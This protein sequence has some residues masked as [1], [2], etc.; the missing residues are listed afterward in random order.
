MRCVVAGGAGFVGSHLC[1]ALVARGHKV[2]CIDN[3]LTGRL[4]NLDSLQ[5][6]ASFQFLRQDV[7]FPFAVSGPVDAVLHL[8]SPAS[9]PDYLRFPLETLRVGAQGTERLLELAA[10]RGARYLLASTSEVYGD[11]AIH[12]QTEEY[13]GYVNPNGPRSVYDE[14]KRFAEALS[15]AYRRARGVDVRVAR[16]FNTYGPRMR[17]DDGRVVSNFIVQA[18]SGRPLTIY[19]DGGQTRSLCFVADLVDGL[20]RLLFLDTAPDGPINIGNPE[21]I[22]I[23][24]LARLVSKI[25]AT[26]CSTE[27]RPLPRDDPKRRCPDIALARRLLGWNPQVD[28]R[29]GLAATVRYFREALAAAPTDHSASVSAHA[30]GGE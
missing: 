7:S 28:A 3:V 15:F 4:R 25:C 29:T 21:E 19:G 22:T 20:L 13:W 23:L 30:A 18:L 10:A 24:D 9:P 1:E 14:A 5:G 16:I 11:P 17:A 27:L 8:A 12:P 26:E 6:S 2:L